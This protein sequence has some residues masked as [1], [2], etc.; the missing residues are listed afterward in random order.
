MLYYLTESIMHNHA[1]LHWYSLQ[2]TL[3]LIINS[4]RL[5]SSYLLLRVNSGRSSLGALH[6][7][8]YTNYVS[9]YWYSINVPVVTPPP[10]PK[11]KQ[12]V[13]VEQ[14]LCSE[15]K[16]ELIN[17]AVYTKQGSKVVVV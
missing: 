17:L 10:P 9:E 6:T 8:T 13:T 2:G 11:K 12:E 3:Q 4:V 15:N 7:V 14:K 5:T 16:G 1:H